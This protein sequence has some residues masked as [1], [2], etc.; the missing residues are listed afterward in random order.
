MC[1]ERELILQEIV[2]LRLRFIT[3]QLPRMPLDHVL[4]ESVISH[5]D[6][7][8]AEAQEKPVSKKGSFCDVCNKLFPNKQSVSS[9]MRRVH[10]ST[11][12][13]AGAKTAT[14]TF[15]RNAQ[16]CVERVSV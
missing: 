7:V 14:E 6:A 9:H 11:F 8:E 3:S 4:N 10:K 2:S 5:N 12:S 13:A 16:S 15:G 1:I